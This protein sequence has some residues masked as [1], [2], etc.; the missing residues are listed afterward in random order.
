MSTNKTHG[1]EFYFTYVFLFKACRH[2]V[3][4]NISHSQKT[5]I[6]RFYFLSRTLATNNN[7]NN[8]SSSRSH[9]STRTRCRSYFPATRITLRRWTNSN[10][11]S[12]IVAASCRITDRWRSRV[13][14]QPFSGN[15]SSSNSNTSSRI[16]IRLP[17][18]WR[19]RRTSGRT[20]TVARCKVRAALLCLEWMV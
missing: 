16:L 2:L 4:K 5:K 11:T 13:L 9:N 1:E 14:K 20:R 15:N 17:R 12:P 18:Q 6:S 7:N 19:R 10:L 3:A 8:S